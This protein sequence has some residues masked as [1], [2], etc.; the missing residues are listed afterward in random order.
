MQ[1]RLGI[2][3]NTT[4]RVFYIIKIPYFSHSHYGRL[5]DDKDRFSFHPLYDYKGARVRIIIIY[6]TKTKRR[7]PNAFNAR[8][9]AFRVMYFMSYYAHTYSK[10]AGTRSYYL[11]ILYYICVYRVMYH[12]STSRENIRM[13]KIIK[14]YVN[15]F[16][17]IYIYFFLIINNNFF[18]EYT[19]IVYKHFFFLNLNAFFL[20]RRIFLYE[21]NL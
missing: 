1:P 18:I 6:P 19:C 15:N 17:N 4:I 11:F 8:H 5:Q 9:K 3:N 20:K 12:P 16:C 13:I 10:A 2:E 14:R 21:I 7:R